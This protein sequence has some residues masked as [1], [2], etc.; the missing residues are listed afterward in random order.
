MGGSLASI[1]VRDREAWSAA[2][3]NQGI[4]QSE[5]AFLNAAP[6]P[7]VPLSKL[8]GEKRR[9]CA[10]PVAAPPP[11]SCQQGTPAGTAS[12][13][14]KAGT[15]KPGQAQKASGAASPMAVDAAA[16]QRPAEMPETADEQMQPSPAKAADAVIANAPVSMQQQEEGAKTGV[17]PVCQMQAERSTEDPQPADAGMRPGSAA[18]QAASCN[19]SIMTTSTMRRLGL[20]SPGVSID[21]AGPH[22]CCELNPVHI[23]SPKATDLLML[24]SDSSSILSTNCSPATAI[25]Q[26]YSGLLRL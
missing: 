24:A 11:Q 4:S 16:M 9:I 19:T 8:A 22:L 15:E 20:D 2:A 26:A 5:C 1:L 21:K 17:S 6:L 10:T 7:T 13:E 14:A 3:R 18:A 12:K 23:S 25:R